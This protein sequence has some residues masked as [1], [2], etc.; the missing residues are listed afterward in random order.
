MFFLNPEVLLSEKELASLDNALSTNN[1]AKARLFGDAK[2]PT[3]M[4][5]RIDIFLEHEA[6]YNGYQF[7]GL[8]KNATYKKKSSIFNEYGSLKEW[9]SNSTSKESY[10]QLTILLKEELR[11]LHELLFTSQGKTKQWLKNQIGQSR[12]QALSKQFGEINFQ[13]KL[14]KDHLPLIWFYCAE[15]IQNK[16]TVDVGLMEKKRDNQSNAN[17]SMVILTLLSHEIEFIEEIKNCLNRLND[18]LEKFHSYRAKDE[19]QAVIN[20]GK[21]LLVTGKIHNKDTFYQTII[22]IERLLKRPGDTRLLKE[23]EELAI[24]NKDSLPAKF[25]HKF[26]ATLLIMSG[27]ALWTL[28]AITFPASLSITSIALLSSGAGFII[29]GATLGWYSQSNKYINTLCNFLVET[30]N[31]QRGLPEPKPKSMFP[32]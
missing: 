15:K 12:Y 19:L 23:L 1:L 10:A 21:A 28:A 32:L 3:A 29:S 24:E 25:I 4:A 27:I 30:S 22:R 18:W 20:E 17:C 26:L 7:E 16:Q 2:L 14:L 13:Y 8:R 11:L 6:N 9:I 5:D 31:L